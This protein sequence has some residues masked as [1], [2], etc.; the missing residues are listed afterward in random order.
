MK[1]YKEVIIQLNRRDYD[2]Y[3]ELIIRT[4]LSP[5]DIFL[6]GIRRGMYEDTIYNAAIHS[7]NNDDVVEFVRNHVNGI[8]DSLEIPTNGENR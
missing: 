3:Q 4:D 5:E 6:M 7:K 2:A 8:Y 1:G